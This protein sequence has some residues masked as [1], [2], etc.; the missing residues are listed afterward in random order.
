MR[1]GVARANND[2]TF[3]S[4]V[5]HP[6]M[7]KKFGPFKVRMGF[8]LH[9]WWAI[10]G[11]IGSK[12]KIDASYLSPNVN[13]SARLEAATP[14]FQT[15]ILVS[16][17][18]YNELSASARRYCRMVDRICVVG[19]KIPMEI[20]TVDVFNYDIDNFLEPIVRENGVQKLADWGTH[21]H[22]R[23]MQRK[24]GLEGWLDAF[25]AGVDRYIAGV[26]AAARAALEQ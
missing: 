23:Q 21:E 7:L 8:G 2:G 4:F 11:A 19:S 20:W 16:V 6:K 17:W 15:S 10:E 13:M 5:A 9:I 1:M 18:F 3:A 14:Q 22:F 24:K 26:F 12:Y 25:N